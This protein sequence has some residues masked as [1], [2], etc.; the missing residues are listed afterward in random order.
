MPAIFGDPSHGRN[1]L[2][3]CRYVCKYRRWAHRKKAIR[4]FEE[5]LRNAAE[6]R[7]IAP[8]RGPLP[9]WSPRR[10]INLDDRRDACYNFQLSEINAGGTVSLRRRPV[11]PCFLFKNIFR[12]RCVL[13]CSN[14]RLGSVFPLVSELR[15][16]IGILAGRLMFLISVRR[17]R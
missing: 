12:E 17:L 3:S 14:R 4:R 8:L 10:L 6:G 9:P 16:F 13:P 1:S 5:T 7:V 2:G 11:C 15:A